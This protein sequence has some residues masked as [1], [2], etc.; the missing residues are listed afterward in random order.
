MPYIQINQV[1]TQ[2]LAPGDTLSCTY[3]TGKN[4]GDIFGTSNHSVTI[5]GHIFRFPEHFLIDPHSDHFDLIWRADRSIPERTILNIQLEEAFQDGMVDKNVGTKI[6]QTVPAH[7]YL[8]NLK[9]PKDRT[10]DFYVPWMSVSEQGP[11]PLQA[12]TPDIPR[13]VVVCSTHNNANRIFHIHG[14]DVYK[15]PMTE[16]IEGPN[17][18]FRPGRKAFAS[19]SAVSVDGPCLGEIAIGFGN[20]LGLPTFIP[21]PDL[22]IKELVNGVEPASGLIITGDNGLPTPT[23][24]DRRGTYTPSPTV[25][26]DGLKAIHLLVSLANPGNIGSPD[27]AEAPQSN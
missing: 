2:P 14:K 10:V 23:S 18:D 1:L 13:N 9:A 17:A 25:E 4:K 12:E 20:R 26:L 5:D 6:F 19:I 8:I 7:L 27:Y 3:P 22:V 21:A 15:R 24:R 11:L 16:Y